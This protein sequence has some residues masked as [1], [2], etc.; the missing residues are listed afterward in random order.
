MRLLP[1]QQVAPRI[2]AFRIGIARGGS[3]GHPQRSRASGR[4]PP[5]IV[6]I[7]PGELLDVTV[8]IAQRPVRRITPAQPRK[9]HAFVARAQTR[10]LR[11]RN[12]SHR[13]RGD[14]LARQRDIFVSDVRR[15]HVHRD[16]RAQ[17]AVVL[18]QDRRASKLAQIAPHERGLEIGERRTESLLER[19]FGE[20]RGQRQGFGEP[21]RRQPAGMR[22]RLGCAT[23]RRASRSMR[24]EGSARFS[25]SVFSR[26][27]C[28]PAGVRQ[29]FEVRRERRTHRG[30][31]RSQNDERLADSRSRRGSDLNHFEVFLAGSAFGT[32][33]VQRD[34]FPLRSGSDPFL[35]KAGLF[36]V[37]PAANEA[38]PAFIFHSYA[39][40]KGPLIKRAMM[41]PFLM[42]HWLRP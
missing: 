36:V 3:P 30:S 32:S 25:Q 12:R 10:Q 35:R 39:A 37:D 16:A 4:E 40:S 33:P 5:N 26:S 31:A 41:V 14:R 6:W 23:Q 7:G 2:E 13:C 22:Q 29:R 34:I 8:Q 15:A 18:E 27:H 11:R 24:I 20:R 28:R 9:Q 1:E 17:V 21:L 38:H 42:P 19:A